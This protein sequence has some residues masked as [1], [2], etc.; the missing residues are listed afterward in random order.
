MLR[1]R[2]GKVHFP[3]ITMGED[4]CF[5]FEQN[6]S[7]LEID[8]H[9]GN[10]YTYLKHS[11][12]QLT[13]QKIHRKKV[14]EAWGCMALIASTTQMNN[15][16]K[17]LLCNILVTSMAQGRFRGVLQKTNFSSFI[18]MIRLGNLSLVNIIKV[19][20]LKWQRKNEIA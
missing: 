5:I 4:Q 9:S 12:D 14:D 2:L 20:F 19:L 18:R 17:K 7:D 8:F 16:S 15:L 13:S 11:E 6:F 1:S 10:L 3:S